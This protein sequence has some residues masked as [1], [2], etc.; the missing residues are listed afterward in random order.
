MSETARLSIDGEM[1]EFEDFVLAGAL[2]LVLDKSLESIGSDP[3]PGAAYDFTPYTLAKDSL[4]VVSRRYV[5]LEPSGILEQKI[6]YRFVRCS[7][8]DQLALMAAK[9]PNN[10]KMDQLIRLDPELESDV[11]ILNHI[12]VRKALYNN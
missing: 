11:R 1:D 7:D 6:T 5:E 8:D 12:A 10:K 4:Y 3:L 2:K 9:T